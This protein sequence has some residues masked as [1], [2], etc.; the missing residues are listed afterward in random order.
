M[1]SNLD[2]SALSLT[3]ATLMEIKR[4]PSMEFYKIFQPLPLLLTMCPY[5]NI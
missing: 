4:D 3:I 1:S 2:D 5:G